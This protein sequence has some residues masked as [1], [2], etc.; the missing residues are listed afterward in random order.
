M[1]LNDEGKYSTGRAASVQRE[2]EY[3]FQIDDL[4]EEQ[5][6]SLKLCF[7]TN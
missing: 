3:M 1:E 6:L 7:N 2:T 5:G 4:S